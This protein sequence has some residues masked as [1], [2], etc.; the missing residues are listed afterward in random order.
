MQTHSWHRTV[1]SLAGVVS[2]PIQ[3]YLGI[4]IY[5]YV[6]SYLIYYS[7]AIAS[8]VGYHRLFNHATFECNK[9][10]HWV[11]GIIG[12]IG[13]NS[14]P[15]QWSVV[16]SG[17]H[18]YSDTLRDPYD[19]TWKFFFRVKDRSLKVFRNDIRLARL[20]MHKFFINY[21]FAISAIYATITFLLC[22][23]TGFMFLYLIP[24]GLYIVGVGVHTINAHKN[25]VPRN[26]W[27]MEFIVPMGGEWL[28]KTHHHKPWLEDFRTET[29]HYDIGYKLIE[30]I[31]TDKPDTIS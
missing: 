8:T 12:C 16:H 21:S 10:W 13:L 20:P 25:A 15:F 28:H 11:F 6:L 18:R 19:S 31:R 5:W 24:V 2:L 9:T 29:Y 27:W 30:I 26:V 4:P 14:S 1:V 7:I 23:I 17:H 22:G 3:M